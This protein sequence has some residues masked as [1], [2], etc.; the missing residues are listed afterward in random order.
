MQQRRRQARPFVHG[1]YILKEGEKSNK[2]ETK[3]TNDD[4]SEGNKHCEDNKK[5]CNLPGEIA[6]L[7]LPLGT[8]P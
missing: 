8:F 1:A 5:G 2:W 3:Q 6:C 4:I 7:T